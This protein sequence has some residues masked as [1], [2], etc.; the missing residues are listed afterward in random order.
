MDSPVKGTMTSAMGG[1]TIV[2]ESPMTPAKSKMMDDE[3]PVPP[4]PTPRRICGLRRRTFWIL[5]VVV[6]AVIIAAA[7]VGG[8]VGGTRTSSSAI[9]APSTTAP[10]APIA[11]LAPTIDGVLRYVYASRMGGRDAKA[12]YIVVPKMW[13]QDP[14]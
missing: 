8:V 13:S 9:S 14:L 1:T 4:E 6:L 12:R 5:F 2:P 11:S 7:I 10:V 3:I